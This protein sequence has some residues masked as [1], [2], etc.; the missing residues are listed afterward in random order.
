MRQL[1][2][3][4]AQF[5]ALETPRQTGHVGGV[6]IL[7]PSTA[8]GGVLECDDMKRLLEERLPLLPPFRWRLAEVPLGLDYPYWVDDQDFDLDFHVRELALPSPGSDKQLAEQVARIFSRPLDR[9]RPLWE[10]YIIHGLESGH[11]AAL[12]KIHH[13]LI[14]GM[15]GAEIMGLLL[16]LEPQGRELPPAPERTPEA[17]P[18]DLEMLGRG[19]LGLPR[20]P[21]RA[22]RSLPR[23]VPNLE[24]TPF[25]TLPGAGT[26]GR[27]AGRARGVVT[28][29]GAGPR[30]SLR[31]P[32]T[33][34]NGR[35]SPH[36]RFAFGQLQLADFKAAKNEY[37]C[38]VNDAVV[39]VCAGVVRRWLVE[40]GELPGEPLVAQI[41]V[42]VRTSE[43]AGTYGNRIMLMSAPLFTDVEDPVDRLLRTHDAMG[44]MKQRHSALPAELLQDANHFIP[45]AVFAR[46]ARATF[47]LSTS[48][49]GRPTWNLVISNVPG[50]QFPLYMAGAEL[51]ANYPVSVITDG[52]GLNITVMSYRGHMDFGIVSDRDQM[53][54]LWCLIDWLGDELDALKPAA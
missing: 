47:R 44:D 16:D 3:L 30:S 46:A 49:P 54:D 48:S 32:K 45:P 13:A 40:H 11:V 14:D 26:I 39:S 20:Y 17:Q 22:L 34:F 6:A 28:G 37:G 43:Q 5:L 36:R 9:A 15:S 10:L 18:G 21:L 12:T 8:P 7:D 23:A 52:M 53:S 50:P 2:S 42:S 29:D 51:Q 33:S 1:T 4:D 31:A 38:T 27:L 35:V 25:G 19:L 24:E 41:P